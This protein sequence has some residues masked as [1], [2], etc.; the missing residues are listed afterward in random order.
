MNYTMDKIE[1]YLSNMKIATPTIFKIAYKCD[2]IRVVGVFIINALMLCSQLAQIFINAAFLNN[3]IDIV[4][5]GEFEYSA[6]LSIVGVLGI[7]VLNEGLK[8]LSSLMQSKLTI[9]MNVLLSSCILNKLEKIQYA[10]MENSESK[11]L[12]ERISSNT[13]QRIINGLMELINLCLIVGKGIEI[14]SVLLSINP[15]SMLILLVCSCGVVLSAVRSGK[16]NYDTER[17]ITVEKRKVNYLDKLLTEKDYLSERTLFL[18]ANKLNSRWKQGY[19]GY[20]TKQM[21]VLKKWFIYMK[22]QGVAVMIISTIIIIILLWPMSKGALT[23]GLFISLVNEIIEFSQMVTWDLTSVS[24]EITKCKEF[25]RDI[26]VFFSYNEETICYPT[27]GIEF[28]NLKFDDVW[29]KYPGTDK[30]ILKGLNLFIDKGKNYALVGIN[31]AG[32]STIIKLMLGLYNNYSGSIS[33]NGKEICE[34]TRKELCEVYAAVFQDFNHYQLSLKEN[35]LMSRS[36]EIKESDLEI[37]RKVGLF[38]L[39]RDKMNNNYDVEL[40]KLT[41][42]SF[43][44]SG[45][46]WQKIVIARSLI[47]NKPVCIFDEP[48]ASLDP[49]SESKLYGKYK[50]LCE[51]CTSLLISHRLGA[52][53]LVDKIYVLNNGIIVEEGSHDELIRK[54]GVYSDMFSKQREWYCAEQ[55]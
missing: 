33:L 18:Y 31:G 27:K 28:D 15:L 49:I 21:K 5:K 40:G 8:I 36:K 19:D 14:S 46:E 29:F 54:K 37:L 38:G 7:M 50:D 48:T 2:P 12:I 51:N 4:K 32:K 17:V 30:H 11:D 16:E 42:D 3:C 52:G 55:E 23:I 47:S 43:D 10:Y 34:Y 6:L 35:L 20:V 22:A 26:K 39:V 25:L 13:E 9:N 53:T 24:E 41:K 44:L 1:K 45:G